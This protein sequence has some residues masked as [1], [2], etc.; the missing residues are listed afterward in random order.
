MVLSRHTIEGT[1]GVCIQPMVNS[2]LEDYQ[3]SVMA[4]ILFHTT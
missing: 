3:S 4:S 2:V 1:V